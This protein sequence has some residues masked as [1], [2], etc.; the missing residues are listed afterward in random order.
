VP[1]SREPCDVDNGVT[2][3]ATRDEI[4]SVWKLMTDPGPRGGDRTRR[5]DSNCAVV[6]DD[7]RAFRADTVRCQGMSWN[8]CLRGTFPLAR[9]GN[10]IVRVGPVIS[11]TAWASLVV[12]VVADVV[13]WA[14]SG[15]LL[16]RGTSAVFVTV[17]RLPIVVFQSIAGIAQ[18]GVGLISF[19]MIANFVSGGCLARAPLPGVSRWLSQALRSRW[20]PTASAFTATTRGTR[21]SWSART[22]WPPPERCSRKGSTFAGPVSWP[23]W[24]SHGCDSAAARRPRAPRPNSDRTNLIDFMHIRLEPGAKAGP[25]SARRTAPTTTTS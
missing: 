9:D 6:L 22:R 23:R 20:R 25:G 4:P 3:D 18:A 8:R 10:P 11:F 5:S 15:R 19:L 12:A 7:G 16:A 21:C 2:G 13:V 24:L 1:G 17:V 14:F